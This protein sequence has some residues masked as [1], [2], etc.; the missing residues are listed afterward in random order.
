MFLVFLLLWMVQSTQCFERLHSTGGWSLSGC[1]VYFR[2]SIMMLGAVSGDDLFEDARR[3]IQGLVEET[4]R[5]VNTLVPKETM[6][7]CE[8]DLRIATTMLV[9]AIVRKSAGDSVENRVTVQSMFEAAD[10]NSDGQ[11]TF[12]EWYDWLNLNQAMPSQPLDPA[13]ISDASGGRSIL[14]DD[15][16]SSAAGFREG[17]MIDSLSKVVSQAV[18]ALKVVSRLDFSTPTLLTSSYIAG[19]LM[20]GEIDPE[21]SAAMVDRLPPEVKELISLSL[22]LEVGTLPAV[23]RT[24]KPICALPAFTGRIKTT[25][26]QVAVETQG[27]ALAPTPAPHSAHSAAAVDTPLSGS[28][29]GVTESLPR[30]PA[31]AGT[32]PIDIIQTIDLASIPIMT[33]PSIDDFAFTS[34]GSDVSSSPSPAPA[35]SESDART[36]QLESGVSIGTEQSITSQDI[37]SD[38]YYGDDDFDMDAGSDDGEQPRADL[39]GPAVPGADEH[40]PGAAAADGLWLGAILGNVH[41]DGR[42]DARAR[43]A[44][45]QHRGQAPKD[46]ALL[47]REN[48]GQPR[49]RLAGGAGR[50]RLHEPDQPRELVYVAGGHRWAGHR[51]TPGPRRP[52]CGRGATAERGHQLISAHHPHA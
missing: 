37:M 5:K 28:A 20:S 29:Q 1:S 21:F 48:H 16:I 34:A 7:V 32:D 42:S 49:A 40:E 26:T 38:V 2:D 14:G 25:S 35:S 44:D 41:V 52:H 23:V 50:A 11:L 43:E 33:A 45:H 12:S 24:D 46:C 30:F 15:I 6:A 13:G 18:C 17:S 47:H 3:D 8:Q 19:G 27:Q 31:A 9:L 4:W 36:A 10:V 39:A 51:I 22:Q